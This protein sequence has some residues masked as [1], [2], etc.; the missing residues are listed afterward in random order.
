VDPPV[1]GDPGLA[2][3]VRVRFLRRTRSGSTEAP[4]AANSTVSTSV[5]DADGASAAKEQ[6]PLPKGYTPGKGRPTPKRQPNRRRVEPPPKDRKEAYRRWRERQRAERAAAREAMM[7]GDPSALLPRDQGPERA[8]VRDLV[9]ARRNVGTW[10]FVGA[11]IILVGTSPAMPLQI[12]LAA[13]LFWIVLM[14]SFVIDCVLICRRVRQLV[15]QRFPKTT[16][17]RGSLYF[18]A[19]TR[20]ITFRRLRVPRPRVKVGDAI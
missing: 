13:Q 17:R 5:D 12:Q 2:Y 11:F 4:D 14:F 16:Q 8:L 10:F 15:W 19:I 6:Q 1:S 20:S 3:P 18:Y 9:D 7:R